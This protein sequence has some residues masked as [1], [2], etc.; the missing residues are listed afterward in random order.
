MTE[1][2]FSQVSSLSNLANRQNQKVLVNGL[3]KRVNGLDKKVNGLDL[4]R[5]RR[6]WDSYDV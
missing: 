3:D 4:K 5:V 1:Q 6:K 2:S